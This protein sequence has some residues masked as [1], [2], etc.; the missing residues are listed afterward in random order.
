VK[1]LRGHDEL[2]AAYSGLRLRSALFV[3]LLSRGRAIGA[4]ALLTSDD[5]GR[6]LGPEDLSLASELARRAAIA[7]E[8]ARLFQALE[9]QSRLTATITDTAAAALFLLD[10][11]GYA[12]YM[13]PAAVAV[14][15]WTLEE[16]DGRR[17]HDVLHHT[18]PDGSVYPFDECP[19]TQ[20]L[21]DAHGL[22]RLWNPAAARITGLGEEDVVGEHARDALAGWPL[23]EL[24][25]RA[26]TRPVELG[27][28]ELWL[29]LSADSFP[30]GTVYAFRDL[31]EEYAI[32][33]LKTDFVSTVSHEL[34]TP[35]AAIYGAAMTLQRSD[36]VLAETQREGLLSVVAS[37]SERLARIV[38]DVLWASR[39]DSG[40][41]D[42]SI[43]S[44]DA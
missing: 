21:V 39:L 15:G 37:E 25:P 31:T 1:K 22:V 19:I 28:R 27:D 2:V 35:L 12:T 40:V 20:A 33:R 30:E 5:S 17:L 3:P 6:T 18:R 16:L 44:C 26:E 29:S 34:R 8:N 36:V 42:V 32:E 9:H 10:A 38:N 11:D 14:T 43:E 4:L 7:V 24:G 23:G 41:M 13:N